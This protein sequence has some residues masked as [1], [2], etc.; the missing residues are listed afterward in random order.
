MKVLAIWDAHS[1]T[2]TGIGTQ[3]FPELTDRIIDILRAEQLGSGDE[4]YAECRRALLACSSVSLEFANRTRFHIFRRLHVP[5]K[6]GGQ[7]DFDR[8]HEMLT[9]SYTIHRLSSSRLVPIIHLAAGMHVCDAP[10][11]PPSDF[12]FSNVR[13]RLETLE[14]VLLLLPRLEHLEISV[15]FRARGPQIQNTPL[16]PPRASV[17]ESVFLNPFLMQ[18]DFLTLFS[19]INWFLVAE[20][21]YWPDVYLSPY[22][23]TSVPAEQPL[24]CSVMP[25]PP[26]QITQITILGQN[27]T[28]WTRLCPDASF[29]HLAIV[30]SS[31]EHIGMIGRS[32]N[33][34]NRKTVFRSLIIDLDYTSTFLLCLPFRTQLNRLYSHSVVFYRAIRVFI[35]SRPISQASYHFT[36]LI[37]NNI[38]P[39][40]N[41]VTSPPDSSRGSGIF[42]PMGSKQYDFV[43]DALRHSFSPPPPS[44]CNI[45]LVFHFAHLNFRLQSRTFDLKT[46]EAMFLDHT[47]HDE[48]LAWQDLLLLWSGVRNVTIRLVDVDDTGDGA[49]LLSALDIAIVDKIVK[50]KFNKIISKG[51][52]LTV[53]LVSAEHVDDYSS[54]SPN[55]LTLLESSKRSSVVTTSA[56]R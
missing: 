8:F 16:F 12:W 54:L 21:S 9:D 44:L 2:M 32:F 4:D 30:C 43:I 31:M 14:A 36:N 48:W 50:R 47:M 51:G 55:S 29:S 26:V 5:L 45:I 18:S 3:L 23:S 25:L 39:Y 20:K 1:I 24:I 13:V 15:P 27:I 11:S 34:T 10:P 41:A 7:R 22:H 40:I 52:H 56:A 38:H 53:E 17:V 46:H 28:N 19:H 6:D 37:I 35:W 33:M 49:G 42:N